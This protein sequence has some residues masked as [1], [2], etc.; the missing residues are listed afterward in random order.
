MILVCCIVSWQRFPQSS[1]KVPSS[2]AKLVNITTPITRV[3]DQYI[4]LVHGVSE[5]T[6]IAWNHWIILWDS[7]HF[8]W[9]IGSLL[10]GTLLPSGNQTW[11]AKSSIYLQYYSQLGLHVLGD[12]RLKKSTKS[13][14]FI[15]IEVLVFPWMSHRKKGKSPPFSHDPGHP[16]AGHEPGLHRQAPNGQTLPG[17][18]RINGR[19]SQEIPHRMTYEKMWK[20]MDFYGI[21]IM[22]IT[23]YNQANQKIGDLPNCK[24]CVPDCI[25]A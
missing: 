12:F 5:L 2:L 9:T 25:I 11:R 15:T 21:S 3:C 1:Y 13:S 6:N 19:W 22:F 20:M 14:C 23:F 8:G 17:A 7:Y 18:T 24:S 4:K 16:I 10:Y